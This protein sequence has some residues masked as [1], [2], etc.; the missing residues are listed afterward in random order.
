MGIVGNSKGYNYA[1][2]VCGHSLE[3]GRLALGLVEEAKYACWVAA[4]KLFYDVLMG[5]ETEVYR[6]SIFF[7]VEWLRVPSIQASHTCT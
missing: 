5:Y 6:H 2:P 7:R 4:P 3:P 1:A